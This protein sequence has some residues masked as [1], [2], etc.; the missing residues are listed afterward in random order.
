M[1]HLK[2]PNFRSHSGFLTALLLSLVST[3]GAP[4]QPETVETQWPGITV[5]AYQI[6]RLPDNRVSVKFIYRASNTAPSETYIADRPLKSFSSA[7]DPATP[8]ANPP[9]VDPPPAGP[10]GE[11]Y[12]PYTLEKK[13][14]LIDEATG[15]AFPPAESKPEDTVHP[16]RMDALEVVRPNE[17]FFIGGVFECPPINP[18]DP[19]KEQRVTFELPGLKKPLKGILLPRDVNVAV[20]F[21]PKPRILPLKPGKPKP[22]ATPKG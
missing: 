5:T 3:W 22:T 7:A 18:D 1:S 15:K 14:Q 8:P 4:P 21:F 20:D 16:G 9:A 19:P 17:G 11:G 10:S 13:G 6:A 2:S 12:F